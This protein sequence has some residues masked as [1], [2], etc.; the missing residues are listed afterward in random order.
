MI[1]LKELLTRDDL[2]PLIPEIVNKAIMEEIQDALIARQLV[3]VIR[4]T[5]GSSI[6]FPK[7]ERSQV[8]FVVPES[9]EVPLMQGERFSEII[10]TPYKIGIRAAVT[11]E[12]IEDGALDV[13]NRNIR[14]AARAVAEKEDEDIL[15]ALL[16]TTNTTPSTSWGLEDLSKL[17]R[18]V[19]QYNYRPN[20]I[21]MHPAAATKLRTEDVFDRTVTRE[22]ATFLPNG[23]VGS[24]FNVGVVLTNAMPQTVALCLDTRNAGVL[25]E[26][27]PLQVENWTDPARDSEG[28]VLTMRIAPALLNVKACGKITGITL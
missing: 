28:V 5:Q 27:R 10:V 13:I 2:K 11:R 3:D 17:L 23:N 12:M 8:A 26:R 7:A 18:L 20:V 6:K 24:I 15:N 19:E 16:A 14:Q 22:V 4:L 21:V 9:G 25:V 1:E